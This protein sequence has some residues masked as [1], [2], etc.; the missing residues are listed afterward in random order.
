MICD[1]FS[2][3]IYADWSFALSSLGL[4]KFAHFKSPLLSLSSSSSSSSSWKQ[5]RGLTNKE[6]GH[7]L[8]K[9]VLLWGCQYYSAAYAATEKDPETLQ[10]ILEEVKD[11]AVNLKAF[12]RESISYTG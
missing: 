6:L 12:D 5:I 4:D 8:T 1:C 3:M 7:D 9:E 11:S 10:D 2:I